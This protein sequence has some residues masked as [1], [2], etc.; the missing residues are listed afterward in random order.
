MLNR[1]Q[2]LEIAIDN[3]R[4]SNKGDIEK[5]LQKQLNNI[6]TKIKIAK[7]FVSKITNA[8][9]TT[10]L[11]N[12]EDVERDLIT[13]RTDHDELVDLYRQVLLASDDYE[14]AKEQYNRIIGKAYLDGKEISDGTKFDV[15]ADIDRITFK[16]GKAKKIMKATQ[17]TIDDDN[18]FMS[19][20]LQDFQDRTDDE[21]NE[22]ISPE[23]A[24]NIEESAP[25]NNPEEEFKEEVARASGKPYTAPEMSAI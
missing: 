18:D 16:G 11:D 5:I 3:A 19:V 20:V 6:D 23:E 13:D 9:E 14:F 21:G 8:E 4:E 22:I 25:E 2:E 15:N 1:K 24:T 10:N 12:V 7:P 17:D